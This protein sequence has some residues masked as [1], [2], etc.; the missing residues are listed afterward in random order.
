MALILAA[1]WFLLPAGAAN[2]APVFARRLFPRWDFPV[3]GGRTLGGERLFGSHKTVR[4]LA[5][6]IL[7]STLV[8][9][10][11]QEAWASSGMVRSLGLIDYRDAPLWLGVLLS[12]GALG[13]DLL[14]SFLKRR[15][16]IEPGR[17]WLPWD[18]LDWM[19][20]A[21]LVAAPFVPMQPR[22]VAVALAL[23]LL[24]S[25]L[26][27]VLGYWLHLNEAPI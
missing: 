11:Q 26:A 25:L 24:T 17:S 16:R 1:L 13:G 12:A 6:G 2:M 21:L 14:K 27:K 8:F 4:G 22:F 9:R 18:Q 19:V 3:D 20:G 5:A 15:L 23:G 10:L 7:A